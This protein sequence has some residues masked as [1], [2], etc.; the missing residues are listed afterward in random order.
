MTTVPAESRFFPWLDRP[1]KIPTIIDFG[2]KAFRSCAKELM[3]LWGRRKLAWMVTQLFPAYFRATK[4]RI[5]HRTAFNAV[6]MGLLALPQATR[7][8]EN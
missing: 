8:R 5:A 6:H 3:A 2:I 7:S 1:I 4:P